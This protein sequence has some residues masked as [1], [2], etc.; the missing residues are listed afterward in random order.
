VKSFLRH[1]VLGQQPGNLCCNVYEDSIA[2]TVMEF[3]RLFIVKKE[4]I[5]DHFN[6]KKLESLYEKIPKKNLRHLFV[7]SE[8]SFVNGSSLIKV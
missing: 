5:L 2:V 4:N 8:G 7:L 3:E 6:A 1:I